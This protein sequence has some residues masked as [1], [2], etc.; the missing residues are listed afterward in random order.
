MYRL[1]AALECLRGDCTLDMVFN[2]GRRALGFPLTVT[3]GPIGYERVFRVPDGASAADLVLSVDGAALLD[4]V[5][6]EPLPDATSI[7]TNG[8]FE[9]PFSLGW[10]PYGS[11]GCASVA[12]SAWDGGNVLRC[13]DRSAQQVGVP[14][15]AGVRYRLSWHRRGAGSVEVRVGDASSNADAFGRATFGGSLGEAWVAEDRIFTWPAN[16]SPDLRVVLRAAGAVEIDALKLTALSAGESVLTEGDFDDGVL[17]GWSQYGP[18][19]C[20]SSALAAF[21]GAG[22]AAC[23]NGGMQHLALPVAAGR[24]YRLRYAWRVDTG[25]LSA[26][27]GLGTSNADFEDAGLVSARTDGWAQRDRR[28][29]I[30]TDFA[31]DARLIF[32][33]TGD[34]RI[35]QVRLIPE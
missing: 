25:L 7:L 18:Q 12:A 10:R 14:A 13:V 31:S 9:A 1:S 27:L 19:A 5:R 26:R 28:I 4:D 33:A 34:A 22:G 15:R 8:S 29:V 23:S 3:E 35:D 6:L 17:S 21:D 30:P 2:N 11:A 20:A 32:R 16:G 24:A